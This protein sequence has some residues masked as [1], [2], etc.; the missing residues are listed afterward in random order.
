MGKSLRIGTFILVNLLI[1]PLA[2]CSLINFD[3]LLSHTAH[4]DKNIIF[5]FLVFRTFGYLLSVFFYT[6][7]N[8]ITLSLF[9]YIYSLYIV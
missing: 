6:S 9:L 7:N 3:F 2:S 1:N 4:F 8:E 5:V